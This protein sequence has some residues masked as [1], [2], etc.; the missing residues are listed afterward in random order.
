M[1]KK[2]IGIIITLSIVA[3]VVVIL[4]LPKHKNDTNNNGGNGG[5]YSWKEGDAGTCSVPCGG[6]T[7][8]IQYLCEDSNGNIAP[9]SQCTGMN[10]SG[11]FP[12]NTGPCDWVAGPWGD[13][14][15]NGQVVTCGHDGSRTR[16]VSC[17]KT[18]ACSGTPPPSQDNC[19][20]NPYCKWIESGWSPDCVSTYVCG[21]GPQTQTVSCPR[22]NSA[23]GDCCDPTAVPP[24]S[25]S[26]N[27]GLTCQVKGPFYYP[28][29]LPPNLNNL[30]IYVGNNRELAFATNNYN[31][32]ALFG[33]NSVGISQFAVNVNV[34]DLRHQIPAICFQTTT[35]NNAI[36]SI[37][38]LETQQSGYYNLVGAPV[39]SPSPSNMYLIIYYNG[40]INDY[41]SGCWNGS[42]IIPLVYSSTSTNNQIVF[43]TP[44]AT[45]SLITPIIPLLN[46]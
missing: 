5:K 16:I 32:L 42:N 29:T 4:V 39:S 2:V 10:P 31:T 7:Q 3:I 35:T 24:T 9:D 18:G 27:T 6:G 13:C 33:N 26:C 36:F 30:G 20:D 22:S 40:T 23:N 21:T 12:C 11:L 45:D 19:A 43:R 41:S 15:V 25:Q 37:N 17:P 34:I 46:T 14:T 8:Y 38:C 44:T 28:Y 1:N